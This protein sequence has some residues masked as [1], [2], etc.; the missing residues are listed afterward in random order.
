M[1]APTSENGP[2][3]LVAEDN[4]VARRFMQVRLQQLGYQVHLAQ[5][6]EE[7][8][9]LLRSKRFVLAFLDIVLGPP[10]DLDGLRICQQ[11]KH[12]PEFAGIA[13]KVIMVTG[14]NGA[15]DKVRGSLAG[16][17]A[18]LTKPVVESELLQALRTLDPGF[19]QRDLAASLSRR[20]EKRK[21]QGL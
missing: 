18:Y 1:T 12:G 13:P 3:V 9:A 8:M 10:S 4:A 6:G 5:D 7:A 15:M 21:A 11:L 20:L 16:C 2:D 14:L 17:D 19:A